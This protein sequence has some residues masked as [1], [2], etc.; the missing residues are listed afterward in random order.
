MLH[1]TYCGSLRELFGM[2]ALIMLTSDKNFIRIQA[3]NALTKYGTINPLAYSWH[4]FRA[5]EFVIDIAESDDF[6]FEE[7]NET[8]N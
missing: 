7:L 8:R 5:D 6:K 3:D 1:G 2:Q 4:T